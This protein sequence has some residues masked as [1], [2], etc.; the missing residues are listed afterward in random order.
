LGIGGRSQ[1]LNSGSVEREIDD[2]L[3]L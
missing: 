1:R 2:G 3:D